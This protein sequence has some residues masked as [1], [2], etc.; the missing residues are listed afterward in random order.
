MKVLLKQDV[1]SIGKKGE[2]LE[3]KEGYARNFLIPNGLAVEASGGALK[4]A[5]QQQQTV[6]RQKAKEKAE[7]QALADK[8]KGTTLTLRHKAGEEGRLFGSI[9]SAE[10][11]GALKEKGL[12]IDKKQIVLE[13]PIR[14][15]GAHQVKV[16]LH[17]EVSGILPVNVMKL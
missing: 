5:Q 11:A 8:L 13:E 12:E 17:P 16:K 2:M 4:Q 10:I 6:E 7:A 14:L 9:T 3:V 15:V 1:K